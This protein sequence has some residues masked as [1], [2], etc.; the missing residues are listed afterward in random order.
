MSHHTSFQGYASSSARRLR[1][2]ASDE[3][4]YHNATDLGISEDYKGNI[5][6]F[7]KAYDPI[8]N[9]I[10]SPIRFKVDGT[11]G[12]RLSDAL[13][14]NSSSTSLDDSSSTPLV[15]FELKPEL[16]THWPGYPQSCTVFPHDIRAFTKREIARQVALQVRSVLNVYANSVTQPEF[17][18][19]HLQKFPFKNL[20]LLE[21]RAV[22]HDT[23]QPVLSAFSP[24]W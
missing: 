17:Q 5:V 20:V 10:A 15:Q 8:P 18:G 23:L 9:R 22:S 16:L 12:I 1:P 11:P 3:D 24:P 6:I 14:P 4:C 2:P 19:W 13:N 7:Q 21:L